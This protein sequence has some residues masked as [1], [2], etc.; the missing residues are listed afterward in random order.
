[1]GWRMGSTAV[2]ASVGAVCRGFLYAFNTVEVTGLHNLLEVLDR[3]KA[4]TRD[5]GLL[6]VCNHVA[7]YVASPI[8]SSFF[9]NLI[10]ESTILSFGVFFRCDTP[11]TLKTFDGVL[12]RTI[13][14]SRIGNAA[15][16][17]ATKTAF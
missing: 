3:R 4:E 13:Y 16:S 8:A 6:T 9:A 5:R 2:M 10:A 11:L 17:A 15:S 1:M 14:V 12:L 7:V